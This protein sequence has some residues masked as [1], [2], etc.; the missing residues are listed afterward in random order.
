[1]SVLRGPTGIGPTLIGRAGQLALLTDLLTQAC[2]GQSRVALIA[3]EAGIG[4][5][6]LVAEVTATAAR[7]GARSLQ[8]RCFE[9]HRAL[10]YGPLIDLLRAFCGGRPADLLTRELGAIATELIKISPDLAS[11]LPHLTPTPRL[12]PEQ[13]KRRLFQACT[14]FVQQLTTAGQPLLLVVEDLH[15]C[16]DTSLEWLLAFARQ[17][18]TQP[19]LLLLTYRDDGTH[20]TVNQLLAALDRLPLVSEMVL[21]RL[22]RADV[23][24]MLQAIFELAQPPRADFL[25]ALYGLTDGN[26]LFIEEVLKSLI[27]AGDIY[28][29]DGEWTRK[30]LSELQIPRTIQVA[31]QQRTRR[32]SQAAHHLL[33]LAALAGQRF[34][35]AV[36]QALTH[37]DES[38]LLRQV[39][40]LL[41]AQ[42][43]V[44]E[45]DE[46]FAF[47]HA[48]TRQAIY[49]GLLGRERRGL[50][51]LV[52]E[53]LERCYAE[54]LDTHAGEL[55][56]HSYEAGL[57]AQALEW[58]LRAGDSAARLYA[59]GEAISQYTRARDCAQKLGQP[60]RVAGVDYAIG[61]VYDARGDYWQ[62]IDAY[63]SA[64]SAMTDPAQ[65][66]VLKAEI[67]AAYV[68][69]ADERSVAYLHEALNELDPATYAKETGLATLWLGRYFY[70]RAQYTVAL[71]YLERAHALIESLDDAITL[72]LFH[73][74]IAT[75]LMY[76]AR[77]E[78]SKQWAWRGIALSEAKQDA[79][80]I[81]VGYLNLSENSE[82]LG[83]WQDTH[84]F[85]ERG[86]ESARQSPW[87]GMEVWIELERLVVAYY[88]GDLVAGLQLARN[89]VAS[90]TELDERRAVLHTNKLLIL[91]ETALGRE[92]TA[93]TIGERALR[94]VD[95]VVGVGIRCWVR[96]ALASLYMQREEWD[97]AI[98]LCEQ[99]ATLL[100]GAENR[101]VQMELGG[102]MAEAYCARGRLAE[103][104][105]L[106]ADTLALTQAS[107]ARHY[108]VVAWRV[109]GQIFT[110][111]TRYDDAA[112]AF[113]RAITRC[114]E[115]GS[116]LELAHA[117]YQRGVLHQTRHDLDAAHLDWTQAR[118]LC[119]QMGARALLWRTDAALGQLAL[120]QH[121]V[122]EAERAFTAARTIVVELA[123]DMHDESFRESLLRRAAALIPA[124]PLA[125][126]RRA[127]KAAFGGLTERE[128]AVA[129]LIAQGQSNREIAEAL[130]VS[131]R[132]VTTHVSNI[133]AKLGFSSRAQVASWAGEKGLATPTAE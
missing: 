48:L 96:L 83:R 22:S 120:A 77:F 50:H 131:E 87:Q 130:V 36:L 104:A 73:G 46:R 31:V 63:T 11:A 44:E 82:Y 84:E 88:Q 126:S 123:A 58:A 101:V 55:A 34:D 79:P 20:P 117:L 99:C 98:A 29:V 59:H 68:N 51:R 27:A 16:D 112:R 90:A 1:M 28:Y 65:C 115:L 129:M 66:G 133:F 43:V 21:P 103:A 42:L 81:V 91:I 17:L 92:E 62:A 94:D 54:G 47:R 105:Q 76:S 124:E 56:Y 26:P 18:A 122:V 67:G 37:Q 109:Q 125:V 2:G 106:I 4:K 10:P 3:G 39:K 6:R 7:R 23:D 52:A 8:G 110:A 114:K 111:E 15:W 13:E 40:E 24:A 132:T 64:L 86:R 49:S 38:E 119:E 14:Q 72:R 74:L 118:M 25:D 127:A 80:G 107:G 78:E 30:P 60:D 70:L 89:C 12:D 53:A 113:E 85:A 97:R 71:S 116:R 102:P 108:E 45:S 57:W 95:E 61:H 19:L 35:F 121:H 41:A 32:L 5:S 100:A 33:T 75:V 128:R 9:Q 69:L 93:Y